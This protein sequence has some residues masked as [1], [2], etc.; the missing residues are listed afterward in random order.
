MTN[1]QRNSVMNHAKA[2]D[3]ADYKSHSGNKTFGP[4]LITDVTAP[5]VIMDDDGNPTDIVKIAVMDALGKVRQLAARPVGVVATMDNPQF[6]A[7]WKHWLAT[8]SKPHPVFAPVAFRQ[9]C[10]GNLLPPT[11]RA[12]LCPK[13]GYR[14]CM[15][16]ATR[17]G[18]AI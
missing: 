18:S 10:T 13:C 12:V 1:L 14:K 15:C 4:K 9:L 16:G 17:Q 11:G 2:I 3:T 5:T 6:Y 8:G 7:A